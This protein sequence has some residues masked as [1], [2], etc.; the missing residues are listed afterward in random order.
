MLNQDDRPESTIECGVFD[1]R[2]MKVRVRYFTTGQILSEWSGYLDFKCA[3]YPEFGTN[4]AIYQVLGTRDVLSVTWDP[5]NYDGGSPVL[6]YK[7]YM[8]FN[9][10]QG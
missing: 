1:G 10:L 5:P 6:G 4:V 2:D 8:R 3:G 9:D 7:L